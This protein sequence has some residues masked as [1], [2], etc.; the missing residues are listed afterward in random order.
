MHFGIVVYEWLSGSRPFHGTLFEII[1]QQCEKSP[2]PL[3]DSLPDLPPAVEEVVMKALAKEPQ[4]RFPSVQA[5]ALA[6]EKASLTPAISK[7]IRL[8]DKPT[9][10]LPLMPNWGKHRASLTE[11]TR[12]LIIQNRLGD[13]QDVYKPHFRSIIAG[14]FLMAVGIFLT[15]GPVYGTFR[16]GPPSPSDLPTLLIVFSLLALLSL[17]LLFL[18]VRKIFLTASNP[19][20]RVVACQH[21]IAFVRR[22]GSAG[23]YWQDVQNTFK[24]QVNLFPNI[25]SGDATDILIALIRFCSIRRSYTIHCR[26]G[27]KFVF[28]EPLTRL[29][30]LAERVET[31]VRRVKGVLYHFE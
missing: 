5:F 27:R 31:H 20:M 15:G 2:P 23:F 25:S 17:Y 11:E 12:Q 30:D 19:D 14:S 26:D 9:A 16:T 7:P 13:V 8:V 29:E 22:S 21:G 24:R 1:A 10:P 6:L 4:D 18:G 28:Q 3:R